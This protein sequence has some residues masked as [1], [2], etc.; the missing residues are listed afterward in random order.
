MMFTVN[1]SRNGKDI[2]KKKKDTDAGYLHVKC[3]FTNDIYDAS[4]TI[5][6][7]DITKRTVTNTTQEVITKMGETSRMF[8]KVC[9]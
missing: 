6:A 1:K 8:E 2:A 5:F 3:F 9:C 7:D 4:S